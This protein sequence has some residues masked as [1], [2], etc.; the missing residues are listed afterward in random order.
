[1][2]ELSTMLGDVYS[3]PSPEPATVSPSRPRP[4]RRSSLPDWAD[5]G[6]LDAA[7][8]DWVPGPPS[9]A[10]AAERSMLT[11]LAGGYEPDPAATLPQLVP[12]VPEPVVD[13]APD[14]VPEPEPHPDP[15]R[16]GWRR[17][18][19][20]IVPAKGRLPRTSFRVR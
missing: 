5:E 13:A 2:S 1:M 20:D 4:R 18:D 15:D 11:D 7:F 16:H 12:V 8:A 6:V 3:E 14:A 17:E 19:D 9:T 10:P